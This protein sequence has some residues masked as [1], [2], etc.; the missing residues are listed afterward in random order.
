MRRQPSK[1]FHGFTLIEF[2]FAT[3]ILATL[4]A[5]SLPAL[6]SLT[7]STRSRA[8]SNSLITALNLA[9]SSAVSR[10][11]EIVLCPSADQNHC[12]DGIWWQQ[13]WIVFQDRD[14]NGAR[15]GNEPIINVVPAQSG[16]AIAS[17]IGRDHVTYRIDGSAT[18]T[19][20]TFTTSARHNLKIGDQVTISGKEVFPDGRFVRDDDAQKAFSKLRSAIAGVYFWRINEA[21]RRGN[22]AEQQR[23]IKECDFAFRQA[24]A[25]CP[26]SPE[27]VFRYSNLLM[28]MGKIDDALM[29]AKTFQKLDPNNRSVREFLQSIRP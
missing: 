18:G 21:G 17:S 6:G 23:M 13:G 26:Y 29:I 1:N 16:M 25:F 9:R 28:S 11:S 14:R 19:N 8:A 4:C 2:I 20:L 3:A 15:N 5:V 24:F 10:S 22:L 27:A 12:D 7:Q